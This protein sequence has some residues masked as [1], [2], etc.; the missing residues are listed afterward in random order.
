M[1]KMLNK[2]GIEGIYYN[3]IN[4][5]YNKPTDTITLMGEF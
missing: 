2:L 1:I 4:A 3:I 5:I